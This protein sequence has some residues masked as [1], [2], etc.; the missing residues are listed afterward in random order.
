MR[1]VDTNVVVRYVM[2]DDVEQADRAR[3]LVDVSPIHLPT[4]V[5]LETEWVLR[6]VY[7][8]SAQAVSA[9]LRGFFGLPRIRLEQPAQVA[10][11]LH[12]FEQGLDFADAL[13]LATAR[14]CEGFATFDRDFI[15]TANRVR[16]GNVAEP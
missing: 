1:A 13:H 9:A 16:A 10:L 6:T 12:W 15:K 7:R 11:A 8:L 2:N 5:V 14:E 4:T 3:R